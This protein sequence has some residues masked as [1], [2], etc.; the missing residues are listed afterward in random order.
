M[1]YK[2]SNHKQQDNKYLHQNIPDWLRFCYVIKIIDFFFLWYNELP[3]SD[4]IIKI[5]KKCQL[6]HDIANIRLYNSW[7]NTYDKN[8]LWFLIQFGFGSYNQNLLLFAYKLTKF[9]IL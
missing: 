8:G 2:Y 5:K 9:K 1:F 7:D 4:N 3:T 6:G